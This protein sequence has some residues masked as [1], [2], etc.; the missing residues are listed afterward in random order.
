MT[1]EG[2]VAYA[3]LTP[4][5]HRRMRTGVAPVISPG[6]LR[7]DLDQAVGI[8]QPIRAIS[9][10]DTGFR[11]S[12]GVYHEG[13]AQASRVESAVLALVEVAVVDDL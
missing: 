8:G 10:R 11:W 12:G 3:G 1:A 2:L 6:L 13:G 4:I 5:N 7:R 9:L